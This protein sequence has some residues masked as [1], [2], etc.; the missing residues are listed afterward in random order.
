MA[1]HSAGIADSVRAQLPKTPFGDHEQ[2]LS[3]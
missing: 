2:G 3:D 1:D